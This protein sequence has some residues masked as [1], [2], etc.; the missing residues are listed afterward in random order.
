MR[1]F[2]IGFMLTRRIAS[3]LLILMPMRIAIQSVSD[4]RDLKDRSPNPRLRL[5]SD[6]VF[7][8]SMAGLW[9]LISTDLFSPRL[10]RFD[11]AVLIASAGYAVVHGRCERCANLCARERPVAAQLEANRGRILGDLHGRFYRS[12]MARALN[13]T[14]SSGT[15]SDWITS[16]AKPDYRVRLARYRSL[17]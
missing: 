1:S 3:V 8:G 5:I 12:T 6:L 11:L 17:Y 15:C 10:A 14:A 9:W 7:A 4:W 16:A 2:I 13:F